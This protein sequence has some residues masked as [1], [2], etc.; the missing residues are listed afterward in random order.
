MT[1]DRKAKS[2]G[3]HATNMSRVRIFNPLSIAKVSQVVY[4]VRPVSK[5]IFVQ[6]LYICKSEFGQT[7]KISA[8]NSEET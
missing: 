5:Q 7:A 3:D 4:L 1:V 6:S 2:Y 8:E